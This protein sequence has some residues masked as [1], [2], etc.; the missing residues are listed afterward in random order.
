MAAVHR[1]VQCFA[2]ENVVVRGAL[3]EARG[4]FRGRFHLSC[5]ELAIL[6]LGYLTIFVF[7]VVVV[8][9]RMVLAIIWD[10]CGDVSGGCGDSSDGFGDCLG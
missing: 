10:G 5:M 9:F 4:R 6:T 2:G 1:I 3:A 7:L 8:I